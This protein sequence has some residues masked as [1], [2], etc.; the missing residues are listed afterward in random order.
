[1]HEYDISAERVHTIYSHLLDTRKKVEVKI[2][3]IENGICEVPQQSYFG[4]EKLGLIQQKTRA[5]MQL[6]AIDEHIK[7]AYDGRCLPI[8]YFPGYV[9]KHMR[10]PVVH[11][12]DAASDGDSG[13]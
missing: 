12:V 6:F 2:S 10:V 9:P 1:M 8:E 3:N 5:D 4:R 7:N 13:R 11:D